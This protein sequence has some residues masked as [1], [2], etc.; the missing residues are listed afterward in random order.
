MPL[1]LPG[2]ADRPDAGRCT[3]R[4]QECALASLGGPANH[5]GDHRYGCHVNCGRLVIPPRRY[6]EPASTLSALRDEGELSDLGTY[7]G[8]PGFP[9]V[10]RAVTKRR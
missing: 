4:G 9:G 2:P 7:D 6:R 1:P 5:C 3:C 8:A 10:W